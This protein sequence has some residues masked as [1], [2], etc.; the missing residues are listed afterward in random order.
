MS[1][2]EYKLP[3]RSSTF[4]YLALKRSILTVGSFK[5]GPVAVG[6]LTDGWAVCVFSLGEFVSWITTAARISLFPSLVKVRER[7]IWPII[8]RALAEWWTKTHSPTCLST[9]GRHLFTEHTAREGKAG[10]M[11]LFL[12]PGVLF[13]GLKTGRRSS[14]PC[15]RLNRSPIRRRGNSDTSSNNTKQTSQNTALWKRTHALE[16][17]PESRAYSINTSTTTTTTIV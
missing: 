7:E 9:H 12:L 17:D 15:S 5:V 11:V 6:G 14:A 16:K 13:R 3:T 4:I 1:V 2:R 10:G 8:R